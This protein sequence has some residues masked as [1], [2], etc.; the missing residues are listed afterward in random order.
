MHTST[1]NTGAYK[2]RVPDTQCSSLASQVTRRGEAFTVTHNSLQHGPARN[3]H[4]HPHPRPPQ[5]SCM[6]LGWSVHGCCRC[7]CESLSSYSFCCCK[8]TSFSMSR[9]CKGHV[10][11]WGG[12]MSRICK[13]HVGVCG[14]GG[15]GGQ[16]KDLRGA[17]VWGCGGVGAGSARGM[18][19]GGWLEGGDLYRIRKG[20]CKG[21][22][23]VWHA[24]GLQGARGWVWVWGGR[25][26]RRPPS[27]VMPLVP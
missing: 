18:W 11:V 24:Q 27:A 8:S 17:R 16:V 1:G 3:P 19:V 20:F 2:Y 5:L 14:G 10:C 25:R 4:P 7:C 9:I 26:G 13:G 21:H 15:G 23:W 6:L 22:M 12:G